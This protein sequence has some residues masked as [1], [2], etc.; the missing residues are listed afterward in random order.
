MVT[1]KILYAD[2]YKVIVTDKKLKVKGQEYSLNNISKCVL[3]VLRPQRT[4]SSVLIIFGL[5]L[6]ACSF[7]NIFN[8][9]NNV[10]IGEADY[11]APVLLA[12]SGG[13]TCLIGILILMFSTEYYAVR[14]AT[15]QG[16]KNAIVSRKKEYITQ[17]VDSINQAISF[18]RTK[19]AS[20]YF[21]MKHNE[22]N[23]SDY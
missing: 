12:W 18:V 9:I 23:V 1:D 8:G 15:A 22:S 20:R 3:M 13:I 5:F 10:V 2:E 14:I 17:I 16:E 19:T 7:L 21:T 11:S 4:V 6:V